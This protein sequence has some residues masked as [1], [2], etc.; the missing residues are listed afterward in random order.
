[1]SSLYRTLYKNMR[2]NL[3]CVTFLFIQLR[4]SSI[5]ISEWVC[6][7]GVS[8]EREFY[9]TWLFKSFS[10]SFLYSWYL[11]IYLSSN[12]FYVGTQQGSPPVYTCRWQKL[13]SFEARICS[14]WLEGQFSGH[15]AD[16]HDFFEALE[17]KWVQGFFWYHRRWFAHN[18]QRTLQCSI[19]CY[20][21]ETFTKITFEECAWKFLFLYNDVHSVKTKSYSR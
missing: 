19:C 5:N 16:L 4:I 17:C 1:M 18:Q 8:S 10:G 21:R 9:V 3:L 14:W 11:F 7:I 12:L 6:G 13:S 20:S 2:L 15:P